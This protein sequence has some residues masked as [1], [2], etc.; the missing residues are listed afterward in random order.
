MHALF[1]FVPP[2]KRERVAYVGA[3]DLL[4]RCS[5]SLTNSGDESAEDLRDAIIEAL[6]TAQEL[7]VPI[8]YK[9]ILNRID[10][11]IKEN[12]NEK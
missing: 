5:I 9:R 3:L 7:G 8:K 2:E 6:N 12:N 1:S 4:A 10:I 11:D